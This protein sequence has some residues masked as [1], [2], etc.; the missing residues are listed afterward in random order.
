M[1]DSLGVGRS[2][3]VGYAELAD[4]ARDALQG[5]GWDA[6]KRAVAPRFGDVGDADVSSIWDKEKPA[7]TGE[8]EE[9]LVGDAEEKNKKK[10]CPECDQVGIALAKDRCDTCRICAEAREWIPEVIA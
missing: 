6:E 1:P 2:E 7:S 4:R 3:I 9:R 5:L 8:V 10:G